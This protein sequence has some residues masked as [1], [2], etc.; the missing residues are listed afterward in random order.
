MFQGAQTATDRDAVSRTI[1]RTKGSIEPE[2]YG[3]PS[4]WYQ[5]A[6]VAVL[7]VVVAL[8]ALL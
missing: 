6:A 2:P 7:V 4:N 1:T 8:V 5:V 3:A